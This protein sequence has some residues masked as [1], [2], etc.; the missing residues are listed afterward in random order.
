MN[1]SNEK[2]WAAFLAASILISTGW[3]FS[4]PSDDKRISIYSVVANYGLPV[5]ERNGKDY[6]GLVEALD[7]LGTVKA[8]ITGD[9]WKVR[10]DRIEAEFTSGSSR[11]RVQHRNIELHSAFLLENGR[12]LV[13]LADLGQLL[14]EILGG[15]VTFHEASGRVFIGS[16]AVHFTA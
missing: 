9:H 6:V 1:F 15:P 7:P 16:V 11:A 4:A 2:L 14:S 12:G 13:P 8:S 3:L 10:Y 5:T